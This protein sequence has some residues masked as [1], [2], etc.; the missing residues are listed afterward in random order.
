VTVAVVVHCSVMVAMLFMAVMAVTEVSSV[1][2]V[3]AVATLLLLVL[4]WRVLVVTVGA[5]VC[6]AMAVQAVT[7]PGVALVV[8]VA[9]AER[10]LEMVAMADVAATQ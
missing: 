3:V 7:E 5:L 4:M 6:T 9:P 1:A 8:T 2:T 10:C